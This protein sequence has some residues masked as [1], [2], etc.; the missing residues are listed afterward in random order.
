MV[1]MRHPMSA[2]EMR[3]SSCNGNLQPAPDRPGLLECASCGTLYSQEAHPSSAHAIESVLVT[4]GKILLVLVGLVVIAGA[5]LFAGCLF[6]MK[7]F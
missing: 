1:T 2:P 6:A 4:L 3:C 7:G 5:L